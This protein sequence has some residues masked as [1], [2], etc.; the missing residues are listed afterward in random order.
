MPGRRPRLLGT[1]AVA[2]VVSAIVSGC[3]FSGINLVDDRRVHFVSPAAFSDVTLPLTVS[4]A[5]S[6]RD[7]GT[8]GGYVF[9]VFVDRAPIGPGQ[10]LRSL[11]KD[12]PTCLAQPTCPDAAWLA[13]RNIY[14]TTQPHLTLTTLPDNRTAATHSR[15]GHYIIVTLLRGGRRVGESAWQRD[16]YVRHEGAR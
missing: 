12:D 14:L 3:A 8:N 2:A 13:Q 11:A 5:T 9:A 16:F 6:V 7:V 4:W 10:T 1:T 15:D